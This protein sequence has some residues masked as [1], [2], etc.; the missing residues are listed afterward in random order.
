MATATNVLA[1]NWPER[2][3]VLVQLLALSQR[4]VILAVVCFIYPF[5]LTYLYFIAIYNDVTAF[6]KRQE[7][8]H[9]I[10]IKEASKNVILRW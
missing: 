3:V 8:Q 10:L 9:H 5:L 7:I 4:R 1:P 2:H 6:M